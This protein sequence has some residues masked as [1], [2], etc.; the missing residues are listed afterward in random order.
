MKTNRVC[1]DGSKK[2][3]NVVDNGFNLVAQIVL[4]AVAL[5]RKRGVQVL[6][7]RGADVGDEVGEIFGRRELDAARAAVLAVVHGGEG[8]RSRFL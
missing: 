4:A 8:G 7:G 1:L 2:K 6:G 5:R 3:T